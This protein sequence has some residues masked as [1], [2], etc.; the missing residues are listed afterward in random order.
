[1]YSCIWLSCNLG[2]KY[3]WGNPLRCELLFVWFPG[4][5]RAA[6]N[7]VM[8]GDSLGTLL[9]QDLADPHYKSGISFYELLS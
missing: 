7:L 3:T 4:S 8:V 2:F 9:P 6:F 1:M 5:K